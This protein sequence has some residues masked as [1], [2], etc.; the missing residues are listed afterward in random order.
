[1][2]KRYKWSEY[3]IEI[4]NKY[5]GSHGSEY[6]S[7]LIKRTRD[8]VR[9]KAKSLKIVSNYKIMFAKKK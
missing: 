9:A 4:L 3:E 6:V 1:M 5:Y 2:K 8:S 7:K